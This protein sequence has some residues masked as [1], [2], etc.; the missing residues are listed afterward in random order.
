VISLDGGGDANPL[1]L[2]RSLVVIVGFV[3]CLV[4]A[5][6]L[7][8]DD[9]AY[10]DVSD[11]TARAAALVPAAAGADR[12]VALPAAAS[13]AILALGLAVTLAAARRS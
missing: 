7:A 11:G 13:G 5:G 3:L 9:M 8:M 1:G 10:R 6:G 4:G 2:G 12:E